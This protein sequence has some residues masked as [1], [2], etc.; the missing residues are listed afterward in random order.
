[1]SQFPYKFHKW[2][3]IVV[4]M[5]INHE[6]SIKPSKGSHYEVNQNELCNHGLHAQTQ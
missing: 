1:M 5:F 4:L 6:V 2:I 3:I